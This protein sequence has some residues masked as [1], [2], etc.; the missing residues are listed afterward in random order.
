[1]L[2]KL[3][4]LDFF[5][6]NRIWS[7]ELN[8]WLLRF[9]PNKFDKNAGILRRT[10]GSR[11]I[12]YFERLREKLGDTFW[13]K[14]ELRLC[15]H[16]GPGHPTRLCY[17]NTEPSAKI[18]DPVISSI[19]RFLD[20]YKSYSWK[21]SQSESAK[22]RKPLLRAAKREIYSREQQFWNDLEKQTCLKRESLSANIRYSKIH[23]QLG[24]WAAI[25]S[26]INILKNLVR[27]IDTQFTIPPPIFE[28][29]QKSPQKEA[30]KS[31]EA[32]IQDAKE[33]KVFRV[34][35][36]FPKTVMKRFIIK[37]GDKFRTIF[38]ARPLNP[39]FYEKK[40]Q[41]PRVRQVFNVFS[42]DA[43][44]SAI[45]LSK[46]Y[47]QFPISPSLQRY[48][49]FSEIFE[50]KP[51][52]FSYTALPF[53]WSVAPFIF[54]YMLSPIRNFLQKFFPS[55]GY[56]DDLAI[57]MGIKGEERQDIQYSADFLLWLLGKLGLQ[58]NPKKSDLFNPSTHLHWLG[59]LI[60]SESQTVV[61]PI[62]K[63]LDLFE[64]IAECLKDGS[65]T[66]KQLACFNGKF[67]F[68]SDSLGRAISQTAIDYLIAWV[69]T[70]DYENDI[71]KG[72]KEWNLPHNVPND[73]RDSFSGW[74]DLILETWEKKPDYKFLQ[75]PIFLIQDTSEEASGAAAL[76]F[77]LKTKNPRSRVHLES[78]F[79]LPIQFQGKLKSSTF[80]ECWEFLNF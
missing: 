26:P 44:L 29:S 21:F 39:Y 62:T 41:L 52:Y 50:G 58:I 65:I 68:L 5:P 7:F 35:E 63:T 4:I 25:G 51:Y 56:L 34:P 18:L 55:L 54:S 28:I 3:S 37:Q 61:A 80:R 73:L 48:F 1:M 2:D 69:G 66:A 8:P 64:E 79:K 14:N 22:K 15:F 53:G 43:L 17:H 9:Y 13:S 74:L 40:F 38:N 31:W 12:A 45:D 16:C 76:T 67:N 70:I 49:C 20:S 30:E 60:R 77:K 46:S 42:K 47:Y 32:A 72:R 23:R 78:T 27:G 36:W 24:F 19:L 59:L 10:K 75:N 11:K 71:N 6:Q 33:G 57:Q